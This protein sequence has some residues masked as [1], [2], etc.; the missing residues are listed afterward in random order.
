MSEDNDHVPVT[1]QV[2]EV[3]NVTSSNSRKSTVVRVEATL[4]DGKFFYPVMLIKKSYSLVTSKQ[5]YRGVIVQMSNYITQPLNGSKQIIMCLDPF[6][7]GISESI[8]GNPSEYLHCNYSTI[9]MKLTALLSI[10][11]M[12]TIWFPLFTAIL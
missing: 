2:L 1:L 3:A 9:E 11:P 5:I 10:H 12:A 7:A 4:S 6:V 8:I